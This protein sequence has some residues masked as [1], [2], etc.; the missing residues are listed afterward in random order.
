MNA[1]AVT[2]PEAH[3]TQRSSRLRSELGISGI[4]A[5]VIVIFAA[6]MAI[7]GPWI[8]PHDPTLT[9]LSNAWLQG[10]PG[11]LLGT[12]YQGRD[13]LSRLL[14]GARTSMLGPLIVVFLCMTA[15]TLFA[16]ISAWRRGVTDN[17][18]SSGMDIMF[19][20]PAILL[21]ALAATVFGAGLT[22]AAIAIAIAYTPYVARVL[23]S[24][25]LKERSQ[26]YIA[27]LEVQGLGTVA[28]CTKH[29]IR[30]VLPLM[31]AQATILFAYCMLDLAA[32]SFLG[33]GVQQPTPDWGVMISE[34]QQGIIQGYFGP[35]LM[36]G[37]CIVVVVVSVTVLGERLLERAEKD[38]P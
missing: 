3:E 9:N 25:M 18:I 12:D 24:A 10:G 22:A 13:V 7:I 20:F 33:L 38:R 19:A 21:A 15:G 36:A 2:V 1:V 5:A 31:V 32:I 4:V 14:A 30:N 16:V 17:V 34:N 26:Q 11:H 23:R 8:A 28:I 29:L 37:L 6:L 27:A 35:S